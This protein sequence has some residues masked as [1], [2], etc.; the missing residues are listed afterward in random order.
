MK[1]TIAAILS[2]AAFLLASGCSSNEAARMTE[3]MRLAEPAPAQGNL[4]ERITVPADS[5]KL[6]QIQVERVQ[7]AQVSL[8]AVPTPARIEAD[9]TRLSRVA[10]P[11]PG[12]IVSLEVGP[13]DRVERGQTLL[14]L[15][16]PE[17][18]AAVSA[19]RRAQAALRQARSELTKA[20]SD[21]ERVRELYEV[22]ALP[23]KEVLA[24]ETEL[25]QAESAVEQVE[26]E[27]RQAERMLQILDL[28][29]D[30]FGQRLSVVS[31]RGGRIIEIN[32]SPGEFRSETSD[33]VITIADLSTV[34]AV[35]DVPENMIRHIRPGAPV[36]LTLTAYPGESF[37]GLVKRLSDLVDEG[38]R[39]IKVYVELANPGGRFRPNMF[40]QVL[41]S[42]GS[43]EVP[44]V[45]PGAVVY[46]GGKSVVLVEREPGLF[47]PREVIVGRRSE[48][49]VPIRSGLQSGE[50]VVVNGAMLLLGS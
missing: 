17:T 34:W 46:R 32:T 13:G 4:P 15:E 12:R 10:L 30:G 49:Q 28:Q 2:L 21:L 5:P 50:Q 43:Q 19:H 27:R 39:T 36:Q 29:P 31:P 24:A 8:D 45:P 38:T 35:S 48:G 7:S 14:T 40:G 44:V 41:H 22:G 37:Q 3:T 6:A 25:A 42:G 33:P 11:V 16:S 26:A 47:E 18:D 1:S 9:P 20:E 23:R